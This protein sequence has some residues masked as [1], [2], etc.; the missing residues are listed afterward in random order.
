MR[1][2]DLPH[3]RQESKIGPQNKGTCL[4][5]RRT[6]LM[7]YTFPAGLP[8]PPSPTD[9]QLSRARAR[10]LPDATAG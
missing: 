2:P 6:Y 5:Q 7:P 8:A 1:R 3:G 4:T 9:A 10:C